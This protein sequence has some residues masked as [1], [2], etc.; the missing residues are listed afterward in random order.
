MK[1]TSA[2]V[3][4]ALVA[5]LLSGC[6][7]MGTTPEKLISQVKGMHKP[8]AIQNYE[9]DRS[10]AD[11]SAALK[12]RAAQCLAVTVTTSYR[13]GYAYHVDTTVF[14]PH[15]KGDKR[16][17]RLTLQ[18]GYGPNVHVIG[19]DKPEPDGWYIIVLDAWAEGPHKTRVESYSGRGDTDTFKAIHHW[20]DGSSR[21]C[22]NNP[23]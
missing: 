5:G 18:E 17:T 7:T 16:H 11:V 8:E 14:T 19:G 20:V 9:V 22:P 1:R 4:I 13:D 23:S 6:G 2:I 3:A 12:D 15:V 21:S 10:L